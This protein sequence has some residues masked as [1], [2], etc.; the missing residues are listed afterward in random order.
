MCLIATPTIAIKMRCCDVL[1]VD[2]LGTKQHCGDRCV[3]V[4]DGN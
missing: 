4:D 3:R 1:Y 2:E